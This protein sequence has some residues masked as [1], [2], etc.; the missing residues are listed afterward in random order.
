VASNLEYSSMYEPKVLE[1]F[2]HGEY[3]HFE[4]RL[5][6][7]TGLEHPIDLL[8]LSSYASQLSARTPGTVSYALANKARISVKELKAA[9]E[10]DL[11]HQLNLWG[12]QGDRPAE[13]S[14]G[15]VRRVPADEPGEGGVDCRTGLSG[16][17]NT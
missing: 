1:I 2:A 16:S 7:I 8:V 3:R 9:P 11:T 15:N 17:A 14:P 4:L 12:I 10:L 5:D 13:N 6:D